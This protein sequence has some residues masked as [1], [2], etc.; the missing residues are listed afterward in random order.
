M[1]PHFGFAFLDK[2]NKMPNYK[3]R[4][5]LPRGTCAHDFERCTLDND[6]KLAVSKWNCIRYFVK[7]IKNFVRIKTSHAVSKDPSAAEEFVFVHPM[8][9]DSSFSS[10]DTFDDTSSSAEIVSRMEGHGPSESGYLI[11]DYITQRSPSRGYNSSRS[12]DNDF[13]EAVKG[14]GDP[15]QPIEKTIFELED[16]FF[17]NFDEKTKTLVRIDGLHRKFAKNLE[18]YSYLFVCMV[19]DGHVDDD[20]AEIAEHLENC[21]GLSYA[22]PP[23]VNDDTLPMYKLTS[24]V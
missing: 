11:G 17:N 4:M 20:K 24:P 13:I 21:T 14:D 16:K 15:H 9:D 10:R 22:L 3:T 12:T 19:C 18:K 8:E 23:N 1:A 2:E 6:P 5:V 7:E